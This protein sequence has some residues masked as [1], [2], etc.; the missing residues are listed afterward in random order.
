MAKKKTFEEA[1]NRLEEIVNE[2]ENSETGLEQSV[3]LYKEGVE[4]SVQCSEKLNAIEQE[5]SVLQKN[6]EGVFVKK[7]FVSEV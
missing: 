4:L 6:A 5:V 2:M 3:K 1:L 7:P